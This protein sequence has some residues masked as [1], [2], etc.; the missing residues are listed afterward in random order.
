MLN[1]ISTHRP[2]APPAPLVASADF[3]KGMRHL[4]GACVVIASGNACE[5]AGLTATAVCSITADPPRL[6]ICVNRNVFAHEVIKRAGAFSI[7]VLA[8]DQEF[9]AKR[10]A[11]MVEGVSG[12]ERFAQGQWTPGITGVPVLEDALVSFE[13]RLAEVIAASTHDMFIGEVV[14]VQGVQAQQGPLV[15]FNSRFAALK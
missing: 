9:I 10:F 12:E 11:G 3:C 13:C 2:S 7:N 5:K 4:A 8:H 1:A 6:L 15:Y 14:G